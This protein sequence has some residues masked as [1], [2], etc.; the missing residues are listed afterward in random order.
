MGQRQR[1][2]DGLHRVG[3]LAFALDVRRRTRLPLLSVVTYHHIYE[4][5]AD[6]RFDDAVADAS[7]AQF[8]RQLE[9]L[10]RH[11]S[12]V[13]LADV[14]AAIDGAPLPPNPVLIAF[15]DGYSSSLLTAAPILREFGMRAVFFIATDFVDDRRLYWWEAIAYLCKQ[16][17]RRSIELRYPEPV[18]V[19][20]DA[21]TAMWRINRIVKNHA[22]DVTR[23]VAELAAACG[24]QWT[25]AL[26]RELCD[27]LI[28]T[29]DDVR[30]LA[31]L[32]MDIGS[33]CRSHRVLQTV[34]HDELHDEL[35]GS[36]AVLERELGQPVR[37]IAYPVGRPILGEQHLVE[38]VAAAGYD[39][40]FTNASGVNALRPMPGMPTLHRFDVRRL[41]T[42]REMSDA[43]YLAQ[44]A[45]P[46]LAYATPSP[47]AH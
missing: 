41:A 9:L 42:E 26:E 36:R 43:M 4:P 28:M 27:Q 31:A 7:P 20:L 25:A 6:Y 8:R 37:A 32:G 23:F 24:L 44:I 34:P 46:P 10:R 30:A 29:W 33:H 3:A 40:G 17:P 1:L 11:C 12:P 16:S 35:A 14:V 47:N 38:A 45:V 2:A 21:P 13:T 22:L 5:T 39:I 18:R 19:D 15:D